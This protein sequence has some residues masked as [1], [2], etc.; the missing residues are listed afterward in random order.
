LHDHQREAVKRIALGST[1]GLRY[2][3][4]PQK[5]KTRRRVALTAGPRRS[6]LTL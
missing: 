3:R 2:E 1:G 4:L 5:S 6:N